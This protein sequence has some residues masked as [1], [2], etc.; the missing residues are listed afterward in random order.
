MRVDITVAGKLGRRG[1]PARWVGATAGDIGGNTR[2]G[3]DP[4]TDGITGPLSSVNTAALVIESVPVGAGAG[5]SDSTASIFRLFGS[6]DVAVAGLDGTAETG[7]VDR[8][9]IAGMQSHLV[10]RLI[11][12]TLNDVNLA[13]A[14]PVGAEHPT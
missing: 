13:I 2:V 10:D 12:D 3:E 11:I 5:A 4:N 9:T 6:L 7:V 8:A 14:R 1:T